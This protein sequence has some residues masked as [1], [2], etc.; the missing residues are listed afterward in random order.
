MTEFFELFEQWV[1]ADHAAT[2]AECRLGHR[3]DL[4]CEGLGTAPALAII[5]DARELRGV[6]QH[7]LR[8]V[9]KL[10]QEARACVPVI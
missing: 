3:L 6:A 4:Y 5:A 9:W 1:A 10:A 7:R 8:A 2:L